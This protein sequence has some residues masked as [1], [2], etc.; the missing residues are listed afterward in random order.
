[1]KIIERIDREAKEDAVDYFWG[2]FSEAGVVIFE[3]G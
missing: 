2:V 3:K 1:M